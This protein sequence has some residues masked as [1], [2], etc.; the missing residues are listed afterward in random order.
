MVLLSRRL[1]ISPSV[2]YKNITVL[3]IVVIAGEGVIF[4]FVSMLQCMSVLFDR[5]S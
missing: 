3:A 2:V 1:M 4:F 5:F